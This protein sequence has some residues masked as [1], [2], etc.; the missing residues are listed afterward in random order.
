MK[1]RKSIIMI[2][3]ILVLMILL[4][5]G[6]TIITKKPIFIN[7]GASSSKSDGDFAVVFD[8]DFEPVKSSKLI[9]TAQVGKGN[10]ALIS[11]DLDDINKSETV[12]FSVKNISS[13]L[14]AKTTV[15]VVEQ[16]KIINEYFEIIPSLGNELIESGESAKLKVE[17]KLKK[18]PKED[19]SRNFKIMIDS[20]P[21]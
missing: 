6:Y 11:V 20:S 8:N 1:K 14:S 4:A 5:I 9:K 12:I 10:E 16:D 18:E 21:N 13:E 17:I 15:K 19:V 2:S 7:N 3:V